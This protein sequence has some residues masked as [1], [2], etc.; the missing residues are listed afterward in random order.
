[1]DVPSRLEIVRVIGGKYEIVRQLG[2]GGMGSVYEARHTGTGRRVAVKEIIGE[3]LKKNPGMVERFQR[4]A[5]ATGAIETQHI[6]VVLDTG[7]DEETGNPFLVMEYLAGEDMQQL[8]ARLGPLPEELAARL[9]AQ[10]C[11]GLAR[12]HE[13]GVVHRDIKPA[14]LFLARR[15]AGEIVVK[16][17]DFGIARVK[18]Q[19]GPE[20]RALTT[21]GTLLGSPL[22]MS[23]EQAQ[24]AKDLDHRTDLWSLGVVLYEALAGQTPHGDIDTIGGLI[25]AICS[26]PARPILEIAPHVTPE[27]AAVLTKALAL[28]PS[29]RYQSAEEML[30]DLRKRLGGSLATDE[31]MFVSL[32]ESVRKRVEAKP[33]LELAATAPG[34]SSGQVARAASA[35]GVS[36]TAGVAASPPTAPDDLRPLSRRAAVGVALF[37]G[38][39]LALGF[40]LYPKLHRATHATAASSVASV[41]EVVPPAPTSAAPVATHAPSAAPSATAVAPIIVALRISPEDADVTVDGKK[42]AVVNGYV[43]LSGRPG[44]RSHVVVKSGKLEADQRILITSTGPAPNA[45]T[46]HAATVHRTTHPADQAPAINRQFDP[47]SH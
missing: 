37:F 7:T 8:V 36:T 31:T 6:A 24:G 20:Q 43:S 9:V 26:R 17:L 3:A 47:H 29:A 15:D 13:A 44:D 38:A 14:N 27:T 39:L 19:V 33:V 46:L 35:P 18:E 30:A 2:E 16:L 25:V 32:P 12:A 34:P 42:A 22:Y 1:M 4:E 23:P 10:A 40:W 21:T 28:D 45:I 11:V 41:T 5:R